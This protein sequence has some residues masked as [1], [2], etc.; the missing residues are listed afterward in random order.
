M[1]DYIEENMSF[2]LNERQDNERQDNERQ[3][4]ER[5]DN[6]RQ[7]NE[8]QDN[9]RQD[10]ERQ[11]NNMLINLLNNKNIVEDKLLTLEKQ[12]FELYNKITNENFEII[13]N[14]LV[15]LES[16]IF[17]L[18][19]ELRSIKDNL[20]LMNNPN[21]INKLFEI[22]KFRL[23]K[24]LCDII[25]EIIKIAHNTQVKDLGSIK[26]IIFNYIFIKQNLNIEI[27]SLE[28]FDTKFI[29]NEIELYSKF[30]YLI[31]IN[32][33]NTFFKR[34]YPMHPIIKDLECI[35]HYID[36]YYI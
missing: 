29:D 22:N 17:P 11:D 13:N 36:F 5:Q 30:Q 24:S 33:V 15:E 16:N 20:F 10:N 2:I 7:D 19:F 26:Y 1:E 18:R 6:E 31:G 4:N 25:T 9:E 12:Y 34:E 23:S 8:R 3:D 14:Q 32:L 35:F 28:Y 21:N 27:L